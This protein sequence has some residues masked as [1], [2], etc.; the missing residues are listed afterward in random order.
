DPIWGCDKV[1]N[2]EIAKYGRIW[3]DE[4]IYDLRSVENEFPAI[5]FN[6]SLTSGSFLYFVKSR[7]NWSSR[8]DTVYLGKTNTAAIRRIQSNNYGVL[9]LFHPDLRPQYDVFNKMYTAYWH[10]NDH[11]LRFPYAIYGLHT[12][13]VRGHLTF[14]TRDCSILMLEICIF[15]SVGQD[16]EW[17]QGMLWAEWVHSQARGWLF[18]IRVRGYTSSFWVFFK[19]DADV[20]LVL[21]ILDENA[22]RRNPTTRGIEGLLD[23]DFSAGDFSKN[24]ALL[25]FYRIYADAGLTVIAP[26]LPIIDMAELVRL[27]LCVELMNL[28]M[29]LFRT[30]R[31]RGRFA[32]DVLRMAGS[33]GLEEEVHG[34]RE[35]LQGQREVLDSMARDFSR[36]STWTVTSLARM[37]DRAGVPYTRYSESLVEYERRTR[38]RINEPSTSTAPQQPDH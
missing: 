31:Q 33:T 18:D 19:E 5:V 14:G 25:N 34:V 11:A 24:L 8:M 13:S 6:D 2:W 4:D 37:M 20:V 7:E 12:R 28:V 29:G 23:W 32:G 22:L 16:A 9:T 30:A 1:F 15:E 27:Q 38:R 26:T 17:R 35:A 36:F 3:Y 10:E 21:F